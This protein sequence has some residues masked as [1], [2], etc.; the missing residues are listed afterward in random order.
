MVLDTS[1]RTQHS[2]F[3]IARDAFTLWM[4]ALNAFTVVTVVFAVLERAKDQSWLF[5]RWSP[6]RLPPVRNVEQISRFGSAVELIFGIAFLTF[7]WLKILTPTLFDS[8]GVTITLAPGVP[9]T[10]LRLFSGVFF[11]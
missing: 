3:G 8:A 2:G 9:G 1:Y 11:S 4:I 6:G 7:W 5:E 10:Y